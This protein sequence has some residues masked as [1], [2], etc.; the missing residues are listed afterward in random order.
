MFKDTVLLRLCDKKGNIRYLLVI[1]DSIQVSFKRSGCS[2]HLGLITTLF[3]T[4]KKLWSNCSVIVRCGETSTVVDSNVT[5]VSTGFFFIFIFLPF[6]NDR[7]VIRRK[8]EGWYLCWI[9]YLFLIF[10][11]YLFFSNTPAPYR[12]R[13]LFTQ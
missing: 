10:L 5:S 8:E 1:I 2:R 9:I 12:G 13:L 11:N 3:Q 7:C 4:S 6:R